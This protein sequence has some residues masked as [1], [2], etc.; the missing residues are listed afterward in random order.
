MLCGKA[1]GTLQLERSYWSYY[2]FAG[3]SHRFRHAVSS[4]AI[5]FDSRIDGRTSVCY[6][7]QWGGACD[8][9]EEEGRVSMFYREKRI[10]LSGSEKLHRCK[11]AECILQAKHY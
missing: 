8:W 11:A 9:M 7:L 5:S 6:V 4:P 3:S 10:W 1:C 2:G